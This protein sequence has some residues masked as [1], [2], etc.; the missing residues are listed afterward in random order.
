[1]ETKKVFFISAVT[2]LI[3]SCFI[4][5]SFVFA[6]D[7]PMD[8]QSDSYIYV[9]ETDESVIMDDRMDVEEDMD[10]DEEIDYDEELD[11]DDDIFIEEDMDEET[12]DEPYFD[13][14]E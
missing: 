10:Y 7:E 6:A 12:E 1:M 5:Q 11:I 4:F 8:E 13:E 14:E 2:F 3:F 9:P